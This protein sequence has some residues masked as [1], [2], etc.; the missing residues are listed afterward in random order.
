MRMCMRAPMH[1]CKQVSERAYVK[2]RTCM[3]MFSQT[4]ADMQLRTRPYK[5]TCVH[6]SRG[7]RS[8]ASRIGCTS[9]YHTVE[10]RVF[11]S[12]SQ[13]STGFGT[14]LGARSSLSCC[15]SLGC[16]HVE[17][18][19]SAS[20]REGSIPFFGGPRTKQLLS[21]LYH[22][23]T[24]FQDVPLKRRLDHFEQDREEVRRR[25]L[26]TLSDAYVLPSATSRDSTGG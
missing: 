6:M 12:C 10:N 26:Q 4:E 2:M 23:P 5:H 11:H 21:Y 22:L 16:C 14:D 24:R 18:Q 25:V 3:G 20:A 7:K 15:W 19:A 8:R 1:A 9:A 13:G 17:R